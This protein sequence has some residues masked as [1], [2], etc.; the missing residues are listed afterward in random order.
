M[1][2]RRTTDTAGGPRPPPRAP[3]WQQASPPPSRLLAD[4]ARSLAAL[5]AAVT[6]ATILESVGRA[7]LVEGIS[8]YKL[9]SKGRVIHHSI[10]ITSPLSSSLEPLRELL[11]VNYSPAMVPMASAVA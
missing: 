3:A 4:T 7:S 8:I 6:T 2:K 10:E 9:D 11:P 1:K 5:S